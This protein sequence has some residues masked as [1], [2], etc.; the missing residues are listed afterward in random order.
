MTDRF[1]LG[2][3]VKYYQENLDEFQ[4]KALLADLGILYY[5]GIG[6]LRIGF[7]VRNFGSDLKPGG[8]AAGHA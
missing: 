6:D 7:A 1:S 5:V 2:G 3:T 4:I 8:S